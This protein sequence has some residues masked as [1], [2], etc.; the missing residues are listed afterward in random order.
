MINGETKNC[1][2]FAVKNLLE[3]DSLGWLRGREEA[4]IHG[5]NTFQK[6]LDDALN[7][8][9]I[10]THPERI[11]IIAPYVDGYNWKGIEFPTGPK[12][13]K[14]FEQNNK[15]IALKVLFVPYNTETIRVAYRSK[16]NNKREKQVNLFMITDG[17]KWHYL[18]ITNLSALLEGKLSNHHGDFYCLNCFNSY[19]TKN[20][21][22]EH[23]KICNNHDSCHI[24]LP[25]CFEKILK[26]N[27]GEKSL[28][29]PFAIYL[30]L[31]CLLKKEQSCE[32]N[33]IQKKK[34][35]MNP[36]VEQCLQNVHLMK[37]KI[38]LITAEEKIVLEDCVKS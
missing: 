13:W 20:K 19:T 38:K 29:A 31:E 4:I 25:K 30:D 32:N 21:L 27:P 23:E 16:Y 15:I 22:K 18:A 35:N 24:E 26:Y 1:Y 3:L 7:Y 10:E 34:R 9:K 28:K 11:S 37:K 14:K 36:L 5:D 33:H 17:N 8:Q 6:A 12:D 2:Y